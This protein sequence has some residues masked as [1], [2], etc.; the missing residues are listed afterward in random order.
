MYLHGD[1]FVQY[2]NIFCKKDKKIQIVPQFDFFI[3]VLAMPCVTIQGD[4]LLLDWCY[5][6]REKYAVLCGVL[7]SIHN[8]YIHNS[9]TSIC[10][11]L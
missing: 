1:V 5:T 7:Y 8:P 6:Q 4:L 9:V 10:F 3:N 11:I 2:K